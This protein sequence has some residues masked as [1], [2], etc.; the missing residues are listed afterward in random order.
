MRVNPNHWQQRLGWTAIHE[1][2]CLAAVLLLLA[3]CSTE[4]PNHAALRQRLV[5]AGE[6]ESATTIA[7][8]KVAVAES[9]DVIFAAR[10]AADEQE[11]FVSG[12]ASFLVREILPD[13]HGHG[14]KEHADNC[15]FCQHKAAKAPRAVVEFLGDA[16]EP[17]AIDARELFGVKPGDTVVIRGKGELLDGLDI[18]HVVANGI[19]LPRSGEDR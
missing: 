5:L 17:L 11:A 13:D 9:P 18:F 14:D 12:Q 3:G 10:I 15:P 4:D 16:G 7:D 19:Y 1:T 8:A 6:P 2:V